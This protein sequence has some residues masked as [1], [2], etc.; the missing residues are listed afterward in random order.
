M[1][2]GTFRVKEPEAPEPIPVG[3]YK[4]KLVSWEEKEGEQFGPYV[5]LEFEISEGEQ[6]GTKRSHIASSKLTKGR[7]AETT[8]KL[9]RAVTALMGKEPAP[10]EEVV[11]EDLVGSDCQILVE[12]RQGSDEGWQDITKVM[13]AKS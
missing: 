9:F 3:V 5:R 10:D 13:P 8:S 12:D 4:A 11:L 2:K 1:A 6:K 7:T